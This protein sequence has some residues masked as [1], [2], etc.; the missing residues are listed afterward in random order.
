[1][2]SGCDISKELQETPDRWPVSKSDFTQSLHLSLYE[3][4]I[5]I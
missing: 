5:D 3:H 2:V 1:M 4:V